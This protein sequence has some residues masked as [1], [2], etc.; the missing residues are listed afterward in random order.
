MALL[1]T[2]DGF[3]RA[4][5]EKT[6]SDYSHCELQWLTYIMTFVLTVFLVSTCTWYMREWT[7]FGGTIKI[8]AQVQTDP[9]PAVRRTVEKFV[10]FSDGG[11]RYH[12]VQDCTGLR[13]ARSSV[14]RRTP[15][16]ICVGRG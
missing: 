8:D 16:L 5:S 14:A 10:Y 2:V 7:H 4:K 12:R 13:S 11:E 9:L 15:C 6:A 3:C 1:A